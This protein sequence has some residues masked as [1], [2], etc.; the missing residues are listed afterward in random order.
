MAI[1]GLF[2]NERPLGKE[3]HGGNT[4]V[5]YQGAER[6]TGIARGTLASMV[7]RRQIPHVR[8]GPRLVRFE[9]AALAAW[10]AERRVP[11]L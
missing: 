10:I 8:L 2:G 3:G 5:G 6:I 11:A 4:L 7:S 9:V 1:T